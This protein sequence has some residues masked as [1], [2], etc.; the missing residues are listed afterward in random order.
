MIRNIR[1]PRLSSIRVSAWTP[2]GR[3][4]CSAHEDYDPDRAAEGYYTQ[5]LVP[6]I[7]ECAQIRMRREPGT[8]KAQIRIEKF[9]QIRV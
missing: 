9:K 6:H 2:N 7:R 8:R 1:K 4:I 3:F 5:D